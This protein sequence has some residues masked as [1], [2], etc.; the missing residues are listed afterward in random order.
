MAST[1]SSRRSSTEQ[2][3]RGVATTDGSEKDSV[4][5][6]LACNSTI[7]RETHG[8]ACVCDDL[9]RKSQPIFATA[10]SDESDSVIAVWSLSDCKFTVNW[11]P[12]ARNFGWEFLLYNPSKKEK[13]AFRLEVKEMLA[14]YTDWQPLLFNK[15][16]LVTSSDVFNEA[17]L[18]IFIPNTLDHEMDALE[19]DG[20]GNG[21][22]DEELDN[23][24]ILLLIRSVQQQD[25]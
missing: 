22:I 18:H 14:L 9:V 20:D 4:P 3:R 1:N 11:S 2:R 8:T 7:T 25:M 16:A 5:E 15:C 10:N 23:S 24:T 12:E 21:Y 13:L 19:Y 17:S 6:C